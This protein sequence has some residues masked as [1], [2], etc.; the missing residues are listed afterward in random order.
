MA[1]S[2]KYC[3][4]KDSYQDTKYGRNMRVHNSCKPKST[5]GELWRCTVCKNER[6]T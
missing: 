6:G 5:S 3:A 2:I 4:C 1:T